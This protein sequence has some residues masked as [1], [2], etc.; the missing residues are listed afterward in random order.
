M[1]PAGVK[2]L[3]QDIEFM[4]GVKTGLYW[5]ICWALITPG[6]MFAVLVYTL[7]TLE[8]LTY[9]G[10]GYPVSVYNVAWILWGIGVA[11]LPLWAIH[12]IYKQRGSSFMEVSI[13]MESYRFSIKN[14]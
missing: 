4:L 9:N 8:P 3:C 1:F 2:R 7:I 13:E 14:S 6:L 11:Q 10:V 12:A 5:R